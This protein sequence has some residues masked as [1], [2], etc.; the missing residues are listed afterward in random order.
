MCKQ[1]VFRGITKAG[2]NLK[3]LNQPKS[4]T[5]FRD[6]LLYLLKKAGLNPRQFDFHSLKSRGARA[7]V[8]LRVS[9]RPFK[10][11]EQ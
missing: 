2:Q 8:N 3:S 10:K 7:T 5:T 1:H 11:H 4:Y 6:H 9:Y